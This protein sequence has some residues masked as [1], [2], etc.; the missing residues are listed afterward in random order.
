WTRGS[1][2]HRRRRHEPRRRGHVAGGR[3]EASAGKAAAVEEALLFLRGQAAESAVA[4]REA[5]EARN[6]VAMSERI[7]QAF[8][9]VRR[10]VKG[11]AAVLVL[12]V[13][14]MHERQVEEPLL[15]R[16]DGLVE[17]AL[18]GGRGDRAGAC[19]GRKGTRAGAKY[20]A[21]ELIEQEEQGE[22]A[23]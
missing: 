5:A 4:M 23:L 8:T 7:R 12:E 19:I 17:A 13:L 14:G 22:R 9:I 10:L 15:G 18:E 3:S 1:V 21:R 6:D 11:D 16:V 20:V 2:S